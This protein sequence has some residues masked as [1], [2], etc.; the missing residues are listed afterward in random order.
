MNS[1]GLSRALFKILRKFALYNVEIRD[2]N[3]FASC[4]TRGTR[5]LVYLD[6]D[7]LSPNKIWVRI[8]SKDVESVFSGGTL[9]YPGIEDKRNKK[10][11][12]FWWSSIQYR[13]ILK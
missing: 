2:L 13:D 1:P 4:R 8:C 3:I 5:Q 9:T 12:Y 10:E 7:L 6:A 11:N